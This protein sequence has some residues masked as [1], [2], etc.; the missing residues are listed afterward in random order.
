MKNDDNTTG[1]NMQAFDFEECAVRTLIRGDEPWFVAADVARVLGI[2]NIRQNLARLDAD[3]KAD[4]SLTYSSSN[5][6]QQSRNTT[7]INESGLYTLILRCDDAIKAGTTAHRFRKWVTA[8]VLPSL[9]KQGAYSLAQQAEQD[10]AAER[11]ESV[12]H[13]VVCGVRDVVDMARYAAEHGA[14]GGRM[15]M[16]RVR[17]VQTLGRLR[18]DAL[19]LLWEVESGGARG[20]LSKTL[21]STELEDGAD[22]D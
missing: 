21:S 22:E 17:A 4:V 11:L 8:E 19:K 9:R 12:R 14:L 20:Q 3:E 6:V 16:N 10:A 7:I 15:P 5:G 13:E 1:L 18:V 2:Q